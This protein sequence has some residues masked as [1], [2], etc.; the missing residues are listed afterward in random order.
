MTHNESEVEIR[1]PRLYLKFRAS[2][3]RIARVLDVALKEAKEA[4][5]EEEENKTLE[6]KKIDL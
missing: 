3:E 5:E 4:E 2:K 6:P 1:S